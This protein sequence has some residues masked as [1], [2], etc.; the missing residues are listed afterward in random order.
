VKNLKEIQKS[1]LGNIRK[2]LKE[3]NIAMA[4]YWM[5][6]FDNVNFILERPGI[7]VEDRSERLKEKSLEKED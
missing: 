4:A 1:N 3:N 2:A 7:L 6:A 5:S